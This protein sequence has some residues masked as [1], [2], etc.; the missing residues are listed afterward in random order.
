MLKQTIQEFGKNIGIEG[1]EFNEENVILLEV[2]G[3][4]DLYLEEAGQDL[5][6]Y[7]TKEIENP[8]MEVYKKTLMLCHYRQKNPF[9][10]HPSLYENNRLVFFIKIPHESITESNLEKGIQLLNKLHEQIKDI[11]KA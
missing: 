9:T 4:G 2:E 3:V 8:S 1:L 10:V 11:N 5:I 7:M 6:M